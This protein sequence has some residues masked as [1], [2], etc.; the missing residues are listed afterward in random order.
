MPFETLGICLGAQLIAEAI[1]G[2]VGPND[3]RE[4]GWS[5]SS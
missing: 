1:G 2:K 4:I 5:R 3:N